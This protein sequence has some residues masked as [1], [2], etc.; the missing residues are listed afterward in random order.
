[1]HIFSDHE[2]F[3]DILIIVSK[4]FLKNGNH[5]LIVLTNNVFLSMVVS[6]FWGTDFKI[7]NLKIVLDIVFCPVVGY[8]KKVTKSGWNSWLLS[9]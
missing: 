7:A 5:Y 9:K 6:T 4:I 1:M 2:S 8:R 3:I